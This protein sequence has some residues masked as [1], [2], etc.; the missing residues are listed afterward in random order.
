MGLITGEEVCGRVI[1]AKP[2]SMIIPNAELLL[3]VMSS[4]LMIDGLLP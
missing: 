3:F 4:K 2:L 1:E